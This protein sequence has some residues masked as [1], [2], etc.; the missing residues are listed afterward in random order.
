MTDSWEAIGQVVGAAGP[1]VVTILTS[2]TISAL[3]TALIVGSK[4]KRALRRSRS[5]TET[6]EAAVALRKYR[7]L[8]LR[9]GQAD[10]KANDP[11]RDRE[12]SRR[13][14]TL[15][16]ACSL[17]GGGELA[18]TAQAYVDT[19]DLFALHDEDTTADAEIKAFGSLMKEI[20]KSRKS[21][22]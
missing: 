5:Y 17:I 15:L 11:E 1:T 12:L 4:E 14:S 16:I 22:R 2:G 6:S 21:V 13:G 19:G 10:G 18:D 9:Y 20:A 8:V 3:G 7:Q